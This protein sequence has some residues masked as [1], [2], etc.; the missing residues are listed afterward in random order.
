VKHTPMI[1]TQTQEQ[2]G[3]SL[4]RQS[5]L[6]TPFSTWADDPRFNEMVRFGDVMRIVSDD[7]YNIS[8]LPRPRD[9][10]SWCGNRFTIL[11]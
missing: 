9:P 2:L 3:A 7:L 1:D 11:K 8:C 4:A 5:R 6:H 10:T